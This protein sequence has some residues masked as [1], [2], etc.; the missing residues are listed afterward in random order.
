MSDKPYYLAYENRYKIVHEAGGDGWGHNAND[1]ELTAVLTNWVNENNLQGKKIIEFACGEGACGVILS[2][3][4]V[5]YHGVDIAPSAIEKSKNA[6]KDYPQAT[7]SLFDMVNENMDGVYDAAL[8]VSGFHMLVLDSHRIKYLKNAYSCLRSNAPMLFINQMYNQSIYDGK[9]ESFE[10][11]LEVSGNDYET[12]N[13][14]YVQ[15]N[16][17]DIEVYIPNVPGRGNT[18]NGY[19]SEM[20]TAGF[21]IDKLIEHL[22]Y[23]VQ[24]P[25]FASIYVHK[26]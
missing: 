13:K 10:Q 17:K 25:N 12:L 22:L 7:V 5:I 16:G 20:I 8:D 24:Q 3:L 14:R 19:K 26:P 2:K 9:V 21:T 11:W 18:E 23:G 4:G 15:S 6:L 1:K